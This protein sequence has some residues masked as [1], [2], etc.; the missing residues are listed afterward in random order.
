[1]KCIDIDS[2]ERLA[3]W[4]NTG[5]KNA[6]ESVQKLARRYQ[7]H[8]GESCKVCEENLE[9]LRIIERASKAAMEKVI[10]KLIR[11]KRVSPREKRKAS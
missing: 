2:L 5:L 3:E 10:A 1:M 4:L 9:C 7:K 8:V 6:P 11:Q